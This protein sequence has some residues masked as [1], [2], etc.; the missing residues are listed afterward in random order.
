[1]AMGREYRARSYNLL[2]RNCNHFTD[3][4]CRRIIG[5]GIPGFVNRLAWWGKTVECIVPIDRM[6]GLEPPAP[7]DEVSDD[8]ETAWSGTAFSLSD[9]HSASVSLSAEEDYDDRRALLA[10]A[11][12]RRLQNNE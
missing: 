1:M 4:F 12:S 10:Q 7:T 6:M 3:D 9:G 8:L 11:A 5:V 2:R